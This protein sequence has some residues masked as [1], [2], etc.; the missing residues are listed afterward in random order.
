MNASTSGEEDG[1]LWKKKME[2]VV[3]KTSHT[4]SSKMFFT[5]DIP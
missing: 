3:R 2:N 4:G 5:S 1:V